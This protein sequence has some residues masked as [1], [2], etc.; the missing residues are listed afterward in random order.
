M[1]TNLPIT[2]VRYN[3]YCHLEERISLAMLPPLGNYGG[4]TLHIMWKIYNHSRQEGYYIYF[5]KNNVCHW[6][7]KIQ[8]T[9]LGLT[10]AKNCKNDENAENA[11][12]TTEQRY[13]THQKSFEFT[14]Y[15]SLICSFSENQSFLPFAFLKASK[16]QTR[17]VRTKYL[18][19]RQ[20]DLVRKW[21]S[22][23][24]PY[25]LLASVPTPCL[26]CILFSS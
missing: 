18:R 26:L 24:K 21:I 16:T 7:P 19:Y 5:R 1:D 12:P 23:N 20:Q 2:E 17:T 3:V 9:I 25:V 10:S 8:I 11:S 15:H 4:S 22:N 14:K 6:W 13:F